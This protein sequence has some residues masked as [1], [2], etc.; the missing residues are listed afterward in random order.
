MCSCLQKL[1]DKHSKGYARNG[2]DACVS[3]RIVGEI[4]IVQFI[5]KRDNFGVKI[6]GIRRSKS[7]KYEAMPKFR[8]C[9]ICGEKIDKDY[10]SV[11]HDENG[12]VS[13]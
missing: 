6:G 9:P 12:Q 11:W 4:R 8:F 10:A 13:G 3:A 7:S 1:C 5:E 2:L